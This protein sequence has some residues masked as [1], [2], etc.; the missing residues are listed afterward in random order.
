MK[1]KEEIQQAAIKY[2]DKVNMEGETSWSI[3]E[4]FEAGANYISEDIAPMDEIAELKN[5]EAIRNFYY[6][7]IAPLVNEKT[8]TDDVN[9]LVKS[10]KEFING[11]N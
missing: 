7:N 10:M 8:D 2:S 1:T 11:N 9:D 5:E 3:A 6:K 4:A